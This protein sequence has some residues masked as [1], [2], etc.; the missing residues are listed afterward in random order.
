MDDHQSWGRYPKA[1]QRRL[2]LAAS[3]DPLPRLAAGETLLPY[4]QG[5]SYGDSCLNDGGAI[6]ATA[7]TDRLLAFDRARGILRCE[8]G[9]TLADILAF[10]VPQGWFLP[11]TPGT[12]FVS[13]GGAIANDVHGKNHHRAGTFGRHIRQ[14]ELVR[15]DGERKLCSPVRN[16]DWYRAT[17]GGLG[18][19]GLISWAEIALKPILNPWLDVETIRFGDL[20]EFFVLAASSETDFEYTVAWIDCLARGRNLGRGLFMRANHAPQLASPPRIPRAQARNVPLDAPGFLLN[21]Y[22]VRAFNALYY[23]RQLGKVRRALTYYDP[24]FYPLDA[25][26]RWNRI[27]GKRGFLQYQCVVPDDDGGAVLRRLLKEIS[28]SGLGSFLSV[29][30]TFGA[31]PGAGMLSFPRKGATLALDFP[32][33]PSTMRLLDRLDGI[34]RAVGGA[35]YP[36]KDARMSAYSFQTYYP[37]WT[38]FATYVDPQFSSGF[39]RRVTRARARDLHEEGINRWRNLRD[40]G[41]NG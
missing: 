26:G 9:V 3:S 5:R 25:I 36:A 19:T 2:A 18:L 20:N 4:G 15:S 29:L 6:V 30:K 35:V 28:N 41:G 37:Q 27:Y 13:V 32:N 31:V 33:R 17:I 23:R 10:A 11:V 24:Y 40:C 21:R 39:W 16:G 38:E 34:V 7:H 12:K 8:A 1:R 22:T 14:F